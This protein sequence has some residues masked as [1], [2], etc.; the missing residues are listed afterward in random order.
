MTLKARMLM[1]VAFGIMAAGELILAEPAADK[2]TEP[3]GPL[4]GLPSAPGPHIEKIKALKD[5]TWLTLGAPA[6]D[7]KWGKAR[8][9]AWGALFP[10]APELKAAFLYGEGV[11]AWYNKQTNRYMDD[12]WAYDVNGHRW[13]CVYPGANVKNIGLKMSADGFEVDPD[14]QPIPLAQMAH[15]FGQVT[16]DG[17]RRKFMFIAAQGCDWAL[18]LGERR[19]S[20]GG[21]QWPYC[22]SKCSP[23]MY[24]VA[25]GKFELFKVQGS[26]PGNYTC[27]S[28]GA[29]MYVPTIKKLFYWIGGAKDAWLYD[30]QTNAWS[31]ISP[32]GPPP[33]FGVDPNVCYDSKRDRIYLGGGYYPVAK[34]ANAFWCYD[35]KANAW[36]DLQP[37]GKVCGGCNRFGP[38]HALVHYDS[39]NDV[40]VLFYHRL[41]VNDNDG[42]FNP[43]AKALG[44]Y[45]YDPVANSWS[46]TPQPMPKVIGLCPNGFYNQELNAHFIHCAGDSEDNGVMSVYRYQ[47]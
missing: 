35:V 46:E 38:N 12:L 9:R 37:K 14:G 3:Q 1:I 5:N 16:Y 2:K 26:Y 17:D 25:T 8:G 21:Y 43:G 36:V 45:V 15:A 31:N 39:A 27:S 42:D 33:P 24:N 32:T 19:K 30:P 11:H 40:V 18:V 23:W 4:A 6:A 29:I 41:P 20:W 34:G 28:V 47:K 13:I 7:P 44:V 22:P 10:Y